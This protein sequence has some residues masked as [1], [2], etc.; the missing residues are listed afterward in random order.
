MRGTEKSEGNFTMWQGDTEDSNDLGDWIVKQPWSN[1]KIYTFGASAD[2][3]GE[4]QTPAG[5]PSWLAG[6]YIAWAPSAM[7]EILFPYGT[8]K[9]ET[10]EDWLM[11]L[12]MPNPDVVYDNIKTVYEHETHDSFWNKIEMTESNGKFSDVKAPS[13]FWAGWYDVFIMGSLTCFDGYNRLSDESVRYTS[14][15]TIDPCGHCLETQ[16]FFTENVVMGRTGVMLGQLFALYGIHPVFRNGIKNVTFYV[17]SSNDEAGK[18]A[19]QY[20]T[21]IDSFPVPKMTD[22]YLHADKTASLL[23]ALPNDATSTSYVFDPSNPQLTMG[24]SNLPDSIG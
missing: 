16:E 21:S 13:A 5:H 15:I 7:Y 3:I 8:Y 20:W 4:L 14:V 22:F 17:M 19:G 6:Q 12:T 24:G 10:T 11:G 23:P 1:G 2:G 18:Q 9:Q